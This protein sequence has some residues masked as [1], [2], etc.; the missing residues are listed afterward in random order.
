MQ[1]SAHVRGTHTITQ[2]N[3]SGTGRQRRESF[4]H[5]HKLY[6]RPLQ[7]T[8][9]TL[10]RD[11]IPGSNYR[12]RPRGAGEQDE[13]RERERRETDTVLFILLLPSTTAVFSHPREDEEK[14]L[15]LSL[16]SL[17]LASRFPV[18]IPRSSGGVRKLLKGSSHPLAVGS[19]RARTP[20]LSLPKIPLL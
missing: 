7:L 14:S 8:S 2:T 4:T 5:T 17:P 11:L 20:F 9:H 6:E 16:Y 13:K 10:P 18:C 19:V 12:W 1:F 3:G 15:V